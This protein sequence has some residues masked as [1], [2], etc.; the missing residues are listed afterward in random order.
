M[1]T[2]SGNK[3][4]ITVLNQ[5]FSP[6]HRRSRFAA[7][8]Y[9]V[10]RPAPRKSSSSEWQSVKAGKEGFVAECLFDAQH[11]VPFGHTLGTREGDD[12][13]LASAPA[14]GRDGRSPHLRFRPI[15]LK[16]SS[17]KYPDPPCFSGV[18]AARQ[19]FAFA[20]KLVDWLDF[21]QIERGLWP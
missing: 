16:Q 18:C 19:V 3:S 13:E 15:A 7:K 20:R 6:Y 14:D 17:V 12:F 5:L 21:L 10:I 2:W 9:N 4:N 1:H 11:L 8:L